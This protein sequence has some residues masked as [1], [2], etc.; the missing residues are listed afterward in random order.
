MRIHADADADPQHCE[1][2]AVFSYLLQTSKT[3]RRCKCYRTNG[4]RGALQTTCNA[5]LIW[6]RNSTFFG[7]VRTGNRFLRNS[8]VEDD[9]TILQNNA[10]PVFFSETLS[11]GMNFDPA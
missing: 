5:T 4:R 10:S 11:L 1:K 3:A 2:L 6:Y 8:T 7:A 9:A